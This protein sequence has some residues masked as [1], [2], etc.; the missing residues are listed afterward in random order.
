MK[1]FQ[2][3]FF[4]FLVTLALFENTYAADA[5][6]YPMDPVYVSAS[7]L[8]MAT[9]DSGRHIAI[10]DSAAIA[11]RGA[12]SIADL[13]STLPGI[14][15]RT[16]GPLGVQTD[17]EMTGASF[18]QVLVLV[19][20]MRVNDP[21]TGHHNLNLPFRP[22]DLER[23]EV[24][25][26]SGSA[27]HGPDAFGGV[28]NLVPRSTPQRQVELSTHWGSGGG[29][30]SDLVAVASAAALR[31]GWSGAWGSAALS[32]GK[33]RS[34][35]YRDTTEF[36]TNRFY[37]Q[38]RLPLAKGQ[39]K[40][41]SGLEDKGFGANDFY[42]PFPSKEWT[43]VWLHSAHYQRPIGTNRHLVSRALYRRHR[44]RFVLW[45]HNPSAYEN[46]HLSQLTTAE[47]HIV[48]KLGR[49][50]LTVGGELN[51]ESIDSNNLGQ[52][53]QTRSALFAE[54]AY[55]LGAWNLSAGG[56]ID[57][58][59][60]YSFE[61]S[62][63][64]R[65]AR[66]WGKTRVFAG[67][68]RAFRAP[69]FTEFFYE[70]PNNIGNADLEAER[71]WSYEAGLNTP[72]IKSLQLQ[73]LLYARAESNIVDYIRSTDTPPWE[74]QN[75]GKIDSRG[76]QIELDYSGWP[77]AHPALS[78]SWN[79]KTQTLATG[80]QSKYVFTQPR[81]QLSLRL[82]HA[83]PAGLQAHWQYAFRERQG[84]DDYGVAQLLLTHS[85][86]YG[87][88]RLR[89]TN[90]TDATYEEVAGVPMPGRW[91]ALETLFDL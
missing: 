1:L 51:R 34:D 2:H 20:G 28:V 65:L 68:G 71:A 12:T 54:T 24:V 87:R 27:V 61:F 85:L 19:D 32:L 45:R 10:L 81:Q 17:L 64:L 44:D 37:A 9:D 8:P 88:V 25:Y 38:L 70:D 82:D 46:R 31:Y 16:R 53:E 56:R 69:S 3:T 40:L 84:A 33:E 47:T 48:Q 66:T 6:P 76:G 39:L 22:E 52:H 58:S 43:K 75:L 67:V 41:N 90:L 72:V 55:P 57:Y 59:E 7:R 29:S 63:S 83:L 62:P 89:V 14:H 73:A 49:G 50:Q 23:V 60:A 91:F 4:A 13:L 15:V 86:P 36:D 74:A 80:L 5:E 26:G 42:A 79:D 30:N 21:Q 78:Y 11:R 18:S 35:G 77:L